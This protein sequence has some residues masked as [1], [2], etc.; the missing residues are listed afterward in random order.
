MTHEMENI[1]NSAME[2]P[3]TSRAYLAEIL[4][5][6]L[7]F[8]EDFHVSDEWMNE[9]KERCREIDE[10]KVKLIP[11]EEGL[12]RLQEKYKWNYI[13]FTLKHF[14]RLMKLESDNLGDRSLFTLWKVPTRNTLQNTL[15]ELAMK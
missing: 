14:L 8:E 9:I 6:S 15:I 11:G 2:L 10:G 1:V 5:E 12:N 4:L 7:D 3:R 13:A